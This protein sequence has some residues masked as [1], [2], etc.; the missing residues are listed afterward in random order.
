MAIC[1]LAAI[2]ESGCS[3]SVLIASHKIATAPLIKL[4][5]CGLSNNA[6]LPS[7]KRRLALLSALASSN[8]NQCVLLSMSWRQGC[9]GLANIDSTFSI[10]ESMVRCCTSIPIQLAPLA[11]FHTPNSLNKLPDNS[12]TCSGC[13]TIHSC[14]RSSPRCKTS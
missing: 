9:S 4:R 12:R 10:I 8:I 5:T 11:S 1:K 2:P 6:F 13:D 7:F 14:A 3:K